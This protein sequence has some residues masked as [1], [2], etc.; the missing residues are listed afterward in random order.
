VAVVTA[1]GYPGKPER[2]AARL[3][4]L[5]DGMRERR[6]PKQVP[7]A[8]PPGAR[9]ALTACGSAQVRERFLCM[10]GEC[11]YL[12]RVTVSSTATRGGRR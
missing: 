9:D 10:G 4:G 8:R 7:R 5:L 3:R 2:Y 12:F 6:S 11:N 1:A